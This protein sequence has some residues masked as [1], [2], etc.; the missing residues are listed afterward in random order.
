MRKSHRAVIFVTCWVTCGVPAF[1]LAQATKPT[2]A[3]RAPASGS[4]Q[5][6]AGSK[7]HGSA[8]A[9]PSAAATPKSA[10]AQT[11]QHEDC[12]THAKHAPGEQ[13]AVEGEQHDEPADDTRHAGA[14]ERMAEKLGLASPARKK[15]QDLNY[16]ARKRAIA[17]KAEAERAKLE[18]ERALE[19]DLPDTDGI[20]KQMDKVGQLK[21]EFQK[22]W[23]KAR[24]EA[25][26]LLSPEQREQLKRFSQGDFRR[27]TPQPPTDPAR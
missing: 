18:L 5:P 4:S 10:A 21:T 11:C 17:L 12:A 6:A 7:P 14:L 25:S 26:K 8:A 15:I 3:T 16:E 19:Q 27:T 22:V 23:M 13:R 2:P 9:Q 20:L 1:A 24:L